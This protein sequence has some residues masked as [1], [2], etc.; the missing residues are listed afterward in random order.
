MKTVIL[1]ILSIAL[2]IV[3]LTLAFTACAV[4]EEIPE[5]T[6][7]TLSPVTVTP[8]P[9]PIPPPIEYP[10][11][12]PLRRGETGGLATIAP[13][14]IPTATPTP[15]PVYTGPFSVEAR[16]FVER[17]IACMNDTNTPVFLDG[18]L[19]KLDVMVNAGLIGEILFDYLGDDAINPPW[20]VV[21]PNLASKGLSGHPFDSTLFWECAIWM[22]SG[23]HYIPWDRWEDLIVDGYQEIVCEK[24]VEWVDGVGYSSLRAYILERMYRL[25]AAQFLSMVE[26]GTRKAV[27]IET[28]CAMMSGGMPEPTPVLEDRP[29]LPF[30]AN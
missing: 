8:T 20:K 7:T 26:P 29:P 16:E 27:S 6:P 11:G 18:T 13:T 21:G 15:A 17:F 24:R 23:E 28:G 30:P 14:P 22:I 3:A 4:P 9:T 12:V 5:P 2:S 19:E 10:V 1:A 25:E